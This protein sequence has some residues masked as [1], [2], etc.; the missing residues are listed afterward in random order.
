M[1][2]YSPDVE[3]CSSASVLLSPR[4]NLFQFFL[5]IC[6][7]F[8]F[9]QS[10]LSPFTLSIFSGLWNHSL[11]CMAEMECDRYEC[12]RG[13]YRGVWFLPP[14]EMPP[15]EMPPGEMPVLPLS[16]KGWRQFSQACSLHPQRSI[17]D[18]T[19]FYIPVNDPT[20]WQQQQSQR[21]SKFST[22]DPE[23]WG[24]S[25]LKSYRRRW[26]NSHFLL[27]TSSFLLGHL[28]LN[29]SSSLTPA[30]LFR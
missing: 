28:H 6:T 21:S 10:L 20:P 2:G 24:E 16:G 14:G 27:L 11:M 22:G 17:V 15:K 7:D 9:P 29:V 19:D 4:K 13:G 30:A 8:F 18:L 3:S 25:Q 23:M 5:Q 12:P 26:N 1:P